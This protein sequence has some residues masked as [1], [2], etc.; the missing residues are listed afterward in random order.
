MPIV[1][2]PTLDYSYGAWVSSLPVPSTLTDTARV[3][4]AQPWWLGLCSRGRTEIRKSEMCGFYAVK[5][6]SLQFVDTS[7]QFF[8]HFNQANY[9]PVT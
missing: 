3:S 2:P 6:V 1:R 4:L 9:C 5:N 8:P 7:T